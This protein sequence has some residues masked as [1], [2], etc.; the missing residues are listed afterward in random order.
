MPYERLHCILPL[1]IKIVSSK[2]KTFTCLM[3]H[4]S[5]EQYTRG[6]YA[7]IVRV[8]FSICF[9]AFCCTTLAVNLLSLSLSLSCVCLFHEMLVFSDNTDRKINKN[10]NSA[11]QI[12][13]NWYVFFANR[14]LTQHLIKKH[15][16][17]WMVGNRAVGWRHASSA[18]T[19]NI[20]HYANSMKGSGTEGS[21]LKT[22]VVNNS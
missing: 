6:T 20:I 8:D 3:S 17:Y 4:K 2:W 19:S 18:V 14:M 5:R 7:P 1:M 9:G 22:F 15:Q 11:E 16:P 12:C 13:V 10:L 21:D